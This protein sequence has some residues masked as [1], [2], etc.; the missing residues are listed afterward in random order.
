V[1][2]QR[3]QAKREKAAEKAARK[4]QRKGDKGGLDDIDMDNIVREGVITE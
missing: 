3:E 1:K 2:R 4:E